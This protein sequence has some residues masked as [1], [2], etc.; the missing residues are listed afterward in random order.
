MDIIIVVRIG[1]DIIIVVRIVHSSMPKLEPY[2][3]TAHCS[4]CVGIDSLTV[5][6]MGLS[7][8]SQ[9]LNGENT[10]PGE[11][12]WPTARMPQDWKG[13]CR[14]PPELSQTEVTSYPNMG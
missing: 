3:I 10:K 6:I 12:Q 9:S 14:R 11:V 2:C 13:P 1:M 5:T 4:R 7:T 8:A